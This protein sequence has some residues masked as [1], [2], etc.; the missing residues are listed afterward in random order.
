VQ[1]F[2]QKQRFKQHLNRIKVTQMKVDTNQR[3]MIQFN[4]AKHKIREQNWYDST[5]CDSIQAW[6]KSKSHESILIEMIIRSQDQRRKM[7]QF[8]ARWLDSKGW[9]KVLPQNDAWHIRR[10]EEP[11]KHGLLGA[12]TYAKHYKRNH[13][14]H[15]II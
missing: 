10:F 4:K 8:K 5:T 13:K 7:I 2:R 11:L 6:Y 3:T 14:H 12:I 15:Q 1:Y 9:K